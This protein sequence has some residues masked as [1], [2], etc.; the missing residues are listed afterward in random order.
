MKLTK[1]EEQ[2]K[3]TKSLWRVDEL[4]RMMVAEKKALGKK[5]LL[6]MILTELD[7]LHNIINK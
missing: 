1:K 2:E 5:V 3:G 7:I 6:E 4:V